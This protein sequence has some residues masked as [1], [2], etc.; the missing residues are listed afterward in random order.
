MQFLIDHE[1][2]IRLSVFLGVF[3]FMAAAEALVPKKKRTMP[4]LMRW[5]S[6]I[7]LVVI[8]GI[9]LRL[10]M[11]ILA[12]ATAAWATS[13]NVG[14]FNLLAL[15]QWIEWLMAV[16]V[17]DALIYAQHVASHKI[18]LLWR[19]HKVHHA[20]R[21]IDV[22]TGARF[23]PVE[24]IFSMLYK[25][26]CVVLLGPAMVAVILFE[27]ILNASAMFNHANLSLPKNIDALMRKLIVTPDFHR[28]HHSIIHKET[29]SNYGFFLSVWDRLFR[30]YI[31][32]P[33]QGHAG[34]TI[35]LAELQSAKPNSIWWCLIAPFISSDAVV[36]DALD[37]KQNKQ[38]PKKQEGSNA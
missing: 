38:N 27:V 36:A 29:D 2:T 14:L 16:V 3:L 20:D 23:H 18:P 33:Q 8:D 30:T 12:V 21:D 34:M 15:P 9:A 10:V 6:N 4:R 5:L 35:G 26:L 32:Q 19:F 1:S 13:N 25:L 24:I 28:V 22:T 37:N 17:L 11:P 7:G 31:P